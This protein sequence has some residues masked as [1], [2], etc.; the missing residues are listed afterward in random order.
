MN[1]RSM[2]NPAVIAHVQDVLDASTVEVF[3][4]GRAPLNDRTSLRFVAD[5]AVINGRAG[6]SVD[7]SAE[8]YEIQGGVAVDEVDDVFRSV[9]GDRAERD[10]KA[11]ARQ[12]LRGE[13]V[14]TT[15]GL[16]AWVEAAIHA[17]VSAQAATALADTIRAGKV[18]SYGE[19]GA[20]RPS[21]AA[22]SAAA[23]ERGKRR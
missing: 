20:T 6:F 16:P 5:Q 10:V 15:P 9:G 22:P 2:N 19:A 14:A 18:R 4:A 21:P 7:G 23:P 3:V 8:K 13:L 11:A 17:P 1:Q 12:W